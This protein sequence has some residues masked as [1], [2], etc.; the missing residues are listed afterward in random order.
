[1]LTTILIIILSLLSGSFLALLQGYF[2]ISKELKEK[3]IL[4]KEI[5][6]ILKKCLK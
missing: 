6:K 1:M 2:K 4:N 5:N 3:D